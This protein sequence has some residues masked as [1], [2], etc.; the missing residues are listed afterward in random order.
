MFL[1]WAGFAPKNAFIA[2]V[3]N[4]L[5]TL[6]R[7]LAVYA[8][9]R[10]MMDGQYPYFFLNLDELGWE[11]LGLSIAQFLVAFLIAGYALYVVAVLLKRYS[12]NPD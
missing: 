6:A 1:W 10:G 5:D 3:A 4:P 9:L 12:D 11:G 2:A 7:R 8:V